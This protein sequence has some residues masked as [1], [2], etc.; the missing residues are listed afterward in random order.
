MARQTHHLDNVIA[1]LLRDRGLIKHEIESYLK[2]EVYHLQ[3]NEIA[4]VKKYAM[5][6]GLDA[7]GKLIEEIL[8]IRRE[9]LIHKL[10]HSAIETKPLSVA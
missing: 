10:T 3:P 1:R 2:R 8:E 4:K 7:Q 9:S 6:F 5:H